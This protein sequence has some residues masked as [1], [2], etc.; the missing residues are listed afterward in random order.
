MVGIHSGRIQFL[1]Q[2]ARKIIGEP[3]ATRD[4]IG[5]ERAKFC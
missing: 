2:H 4:A 3:G 5:R 1:E